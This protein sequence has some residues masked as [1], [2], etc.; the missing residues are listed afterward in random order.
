MG[1][2]WLATQ[3]VI[4]RR[5]SETLRRAQIVDMIARARD[6]AR[7]DAL[8]L[9]PNVEP[10][11]S[12]ELV[13]ACRSRGIRALLWLPVL[14]DAVGVAQRTDS[15]V[16]SC[17]GVHGQGT[18]GAW[19]GL[20]RGEER[21]L[22]SCPNNTRFLDD[23]FTAY[24]A[25]LAGAEVDGVMLDKIRFPSPSNGFEALLG[26]FC[27]SCRSLF[28]SQTGRSFE[29][30]RTRARE[31]LSQLHQAGPEP[32][33]AGWKDTGSCWIAA[34]L[35]EL[36]A[37]RSL[38]ILAAVRRFSVLARSRGLEVGLDLFAPSL[39]P[40]VSQD[41]EA[42]SGLCNWVKPM[43][44]CRAAGPAG[45]PL[46]IA[47]LWKGLQ[48]LHPQSDPAVMRRSLCELFHWE[49]PRTETELLACGFPATVISSEL[50]AIGRMRLAAGV[51]TYAGI[52]GVRI[53]EFGIDV[54]AD[55]LG[56]SLREVR[57]PASGVVASWNLLH[58]PLENLRALGE[59][60]G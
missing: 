24:S 11:L 2:P 54:T 38:S 7:I 9:W 47:S 36:A 29:E 46:E 35:E 33:L 56:H 51:K 27:D 53:P 41:Y 12:G 17:N 10:G 50:E 57:A 52:E 25:I 49:I 14:S 39:A 45:L 4:G 20:S 30:C 28:E 48:A 18:A 59:W 31:L 13:R 44:Y 6:V 3:L 58:I 37:F 8:I 5:E 23:V 21:F 43:L 1:S 16:V 22:F 34:G 15:L 60:K 55:I 40:L 42:L 19:E 32:L 26:C